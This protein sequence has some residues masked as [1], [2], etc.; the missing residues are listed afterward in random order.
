MINEGVL[1]WFSHVEKMDNDSIAKRVYVKECAVIC[2]VGQ[3]Q[4]SWTDTVKDFKK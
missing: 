4:K 1:W 3:L 2:S